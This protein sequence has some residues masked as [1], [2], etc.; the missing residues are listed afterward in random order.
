[1]RIVDTGLHR[2]GAIQPQGNSRYNQVSEQ[3]I[4][5]R[6]FPIFAE[7]NPNPARPQDEPYWVSAYRMQPDIFFLVIYQ[8]AAVCNNPMLADAER[9][10]V[11]MEIAHLSVGST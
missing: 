5:L 7:V 4:I 10:K 3:G 2:E 8:P 11:A 1:M 6:R 9:N